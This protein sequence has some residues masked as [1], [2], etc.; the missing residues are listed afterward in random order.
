MTLIRR[1]APLLRAGLIVLFGLLVMLQT[2]SFPGQFAY[3]AAQD[4]DQAWLRWPLTAFVAI[5]ILCVQVVLVCTWR[6][7]GMIGE[8]RIFSH[9]ATRWVDVII[10][11]FCAAW[12]LAAGGALWA[13]QG[14]DD[15][16]GPILLLTVLAFGAVFG[17][18]VVVLRELLRQATALRTELAAVI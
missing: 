11:A 2:F 3:Q 16:G 15:P 8:D 12:L 5:E 14:A 4:P 18:V 9:A 7:L 13:V 1:V 10:A 6:L 17:L